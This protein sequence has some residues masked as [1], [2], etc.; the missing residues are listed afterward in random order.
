MLHTHALIC[1][2]WHIKA[3]RVINIFYRVYTISFLQYNEAAA[4]GVRSL[5]KWSTVR[6]IKY[7]SKF[8]HWICTMREYN[9]NFWILLFYLVKHMAFFVIANFSLLLTWQVCYKCR[10]VQNGF[11]MVWKLWP[12]TYTFLMATIVH[13]GGFHLHLLTFPFIYQFNSR[14]DILVHSS[15]AND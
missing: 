3:V 4:A 10:C 14:I 7:V 8:S 6:K 1:D 13:A 11:L 2:I 15:F 9:C 12:F 5:L